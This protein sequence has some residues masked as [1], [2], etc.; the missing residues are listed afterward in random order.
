VRRI[1]TNYSTLVWSADGRSVTKARPPGDG[2]RD[3]FTNELRVN[4]MLLAD[5]PPPV[6]A[7]A[8]VAHDVRI[9]SLTFVAV[10][11]E[12]L[13]P[14][15][16]S[17]LPADD[18]AAV[19]GLAGRLAGYHPRRRW[20]RRLNSARRIEHARRSGLL[21]DGGASR[22]T[23]LASRVHTRRRFGHGDLTARNVLRH[24]GGL[25]LIDWE[26]AGLYPPGYDLAFLWFSLGDIDGG[27]AEVERCAAAV[28]VDGAGFLLSA[29]LIQL[30]HLRWFVA[31]PE[32]RARHLATRDQLLARLLG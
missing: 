15:Y 3:R 18:I 23:D 28:G 6:G 14:K 31:Q 19:A 4:R 21:D 24:D 12:P 2:V 9:R 8:L 11:G 22:L 30:W 7:P 16:P 32:F 1:D 5:P 20:F 29:L 17:D 25:A 27:R 10:P 13:G 26:W